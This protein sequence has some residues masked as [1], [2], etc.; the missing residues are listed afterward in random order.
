M[1]IDIFPS[2]HK[3]ETLI[4]EL[5]LIFK[6]CLYEVKASSVER[7]FNFFFDTPQINI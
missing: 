5:L 3:Q 7:N 1:I 4:P 2:E 6:N